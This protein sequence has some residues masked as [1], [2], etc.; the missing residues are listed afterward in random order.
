[1][2]CSSEKA[3]YWDE[4]G[5]AVAVSLRGG[6]RMRMTDVVRKRERRR[7]KEKER[8][9]EEKDGRRRTSSR[10]SRRKDREASAAR[11]SKEQE[12][13]REQGEKTTGRERGRQHLKVEYMRAFSPAA[14]AALAAEYS[15][16]EGEGWAAAVSWKSA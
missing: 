15:D 3:E 4:A 2:I 7:G 5:E 6:R 16:E 8:E 12:R 1:M 10:R 13:T 11:R 9:K 14:G